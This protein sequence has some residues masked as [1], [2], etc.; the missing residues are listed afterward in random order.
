[1]PDLVL[2]T[3]QWGQ[4]YGITNRVGR[5]GDA[6]VSR[7]V[8]LALAGGIREVDTHRAQRAEQGY[9]DAQARLAPWATRFQITT[10]VYA[11]SGE[12]IRDQLT[13]SL[14]ELTVDTV[15]A[16]LIHDWTTVDDGRAREAARALAA[17]VDDGLCRYVG[18]SAYD[19]ADVLRAWDL[20]GPSVALQVPVSVL[21]QRLPRDGAAMEVL[22]RSPLVHVRSVFAQGLLL[23]HPVPTPWSDHP[24]VYRWRRAMAR[25]RIDAVEACLSFV[26]TL[27][28]VDGVVVGVADAEQLEEILQAWSR[29]PVTVDWTDFASDDPAL[30]DP[31]R[32]R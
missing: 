16:C 2:G 27:E 3:A 28:W 19:A 26:R 14:R 22:N 10:K 24:D 13:R 6:E 31:R 18:V 25:H 1:M 21:D 32:W 5:P 9:G 17:L 30:V 7:I 23:P 11:G 29:P 12:P 8:A 15:R 4:G 20:F